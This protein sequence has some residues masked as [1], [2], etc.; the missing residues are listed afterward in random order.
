MHLQRT[1]AEL[2]RAVLAQQK[3]I[4]A[5]ERTLGALGAALESL[6]G[7]ARDAAQPLDEKPPHY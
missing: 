7:G 4:E 3:Q 6:A 1:V 2:D 5:F